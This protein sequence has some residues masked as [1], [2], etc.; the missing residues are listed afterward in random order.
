[1]VEV[2]LSLVYLSNAITD[3]DRIGHLSQRQWGEIFWLFACRIAFKEPTFP[4]SSFM[5]VSSLFT[6]HKFLSLFISTLWRR[7]FLITA[8]KIQRFN[9][10]HQIY[11]SR[12]SYHLSRLEFKN[13]IK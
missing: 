11:I 1:V 5:L 13:S 10:L 12:K 7:V 6:F 8:K 2:D 3:V 9:W 4:C